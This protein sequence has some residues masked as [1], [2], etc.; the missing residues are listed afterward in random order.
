MFVFIFG[1]LLFL[2]LLSPGH[3]INSTSP[4][5][6]AAWIAE[7]RSNFPTKDRIKAKQAGSGSE[8]AADKKTAAAAA[9]G[10]A[11]KDKDSTAAA[12]TTAP[13]GA[14]STTGLTAL[15][16]QQQK[17]E[18]LR[19]QLEKVESSI[20]RK[21]EQQDEGDEMRDVEGGG[22]GANAEKD[23]NDSDASSDSKNG[24]DDEAPE[25]VPIRTE[26][27]ASVAAAAAAAAAKGVIPP[28]AKKADPT[29]HCKYY[30]TG[31]T[32]G[33]K[34]KCRFVHDP[35]VREAALQERER[36]GGRM[37][38]RQR[39]VLN[40]KD[41]EDLTIVKTLQYL[42]E[43][44]RMPGVSAP[45]GPSNKQAGGGQQPSSSA[46]S[47]TPSGV[48]IPTGPAVKQ[49]SGVASLPTAPSMAK[50]HQSQQQQQQ[51]VQPMQVDSG[52]AS[53]PT[54]RY[55]GWDLS[56]FGNTGVK[57]EDA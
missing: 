49:E 45:L 6:I 18:K 40:D 28:A 35:A 1:F 14:K 38:L 10:D 43:K 13:G 2:P 51:L 20:K 54:V 48:T 39:L 12:G 41:Q 42:K 19:K 36:N 11:A 53:A 16:R 22:E 4:V 8:S 27:A 57:S 17:A 50:N 3:V 34:G 33:K 47:G 46:S 29:K 30:S 44:G 21:R 24:S 55:Q 5:D 32:C 7:R 37:T 31:G 25:A 52:A 26:T 15:E 23:G 9:A 56:G